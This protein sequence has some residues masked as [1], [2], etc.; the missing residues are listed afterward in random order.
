MRTYTLHS[1]RDR[2][3]TR[4][5]QI[6]LQA[7][8]SISQLFLFFNVEN[9]VYPHSSNKN[10]PVTGDA[11]FKHDPDYKPRHAVGDK[12]YRTEA[13]PKQSLAGRVQ[14]SRW[15]SCH[16]MQTGREPRKPTRS[17]VPQEPKKPGPGPATYSL[18]DPWEVKVKCRRVA[19]PSNVF[20]MCIGNDCQ[21]FLIFPT[22]IG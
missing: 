20:S 10:H 14:E 5:F 7:K 16:S 8:S 17:R 1:T 18:Q 19:T 15:Q 9:L 11:A 22:V 3:I 4:T 6:H 12:W 2:N 13:G 21:C